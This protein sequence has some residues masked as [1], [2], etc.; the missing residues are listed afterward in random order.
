MVVLSFQHP[1]AYKRRMS[2]W[3]QTPPEVLAA[4]E[5]GWTIL[6]GNQR[7][8]RTLRQSFHAEQR[9][10]GARGWAPP[11][12]YAWETWLG[13]LWRNLVVEGHTSALLLNAHQ[14]HAL[15]REILRAD[16][17]LGASLRPVDSLAE[18]AASGWALLNR[19]GARRDLTRYADTADT[20]AFARWVAEFERRCARGGYLSA[21]RLPEVLAEAF[22]RGDLS[23]GDLSA[24][25]GGGILLVGF[26]RISPDH[27]A[28][29]AAVERAGIPVEE[30]DED[31][32]AGSTQDTTLVAATNEQAE[33]EGCARWLRE[34]LRARP[35]AQAAVIVPELGDLRRRLDR[36]F[37]ELLAPELEDIAAGSGGG[38]YEFSLGVPLA[39]TGLVGTALDLLEWAVKPL[40]VEQVSRLLLSPYLAA[41][42]EYVAR[43]EFDAFALRRETLLV[44]EVS[45]DE[46]LRLASGIR[47]RA[48]LPVLLRYLTAAQRLVER[49]RPAEGQRSHAAWCAV[50]QQFLDTFGWTGGQADDSLEFQIRR[51]WAGVLDELASL[52]FEG[53]TIS[54]TQALDELRRI[55]AGTLFAP[56]SHDAPVQVM[57]P[58]EAA[59]SRFDA[60]WF[61]RAG[62]L[63]WPAGRGAHPLLPQ[64]LQ[65]ERKMPGADPAEESE[66][67]RAIA[68][69]IAASAGTVVF[70]YAQ[71]TSESHQRPSAALAGLALR[72]ATMD[73]LVPAE[74]ARAPVLLERL[75]DEQAIAALPD[76][77]VRGGS[78]IL[79]L[80]AACAFRAFA[81][82]RL[83]SAGLDAPEAGL[84][85]IERG[86]LV[87]AILED[88]WTE[89]E[90]QSALKSLTTAERAEMLARSIGIALDEHVRE[91][92]GWSAAYLEVERERLLTLL[93]RWLEKELERPPFRVLSHEEKVDDFAVGPL[94]VQVRLDRVDVLLRN[95]EAAG[96]I[97]LDYKTGSAA[98][99]DWKGERPDSPQVPLYALVRE[100]GS[101]VG[102]AF[103]TVRPGK[104]MALAGLQAEAGVLGKGKVVLLEEQVEEWRRVL[105]RLAEEFC[106]GVATVAPKQYPTTCRHCEQRLLCRLDPRTLE[107]ESLDDMA[108]PE[109]TDAE[110]ELA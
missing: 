77:V 20:R 75:E 100:P 3:S 49:V 10:A 101:L 82:K 47:N 6:T 76:R 29:L 89:L 79:E 27:K 103:G 67:A 13:T 17:E 86:N 78:K 7:A 80:Q 72:A 69:R 57:G 98:P 54:Y 51:R 8:A 104:G 11:A 15:W 44:P 58:L 63:S 87:H 95:G 5:R 36:A 81:E 91:A 24:E 45:T 107:A 19:F 96:E 1:Q 16:G 62:D 71:E 66:L 73:S 59:G 70:S 102:V 90:T 55:A 4:L 37:R 2:D 32:S 28:L 25:S 14:E 61:L 22:A 34:F 83:S 105:T 23:R 99:A 18:L 106:A 40:A 108:E 38:P 88:V 46:L 56:E 94:R 21:A 109:W 85:A 26:D 92:A 43:A 97:V 35:R 74:T 53:R 84:D 39:S 110:A 30:G 33:L 42:G 60:V 31:Q 65:R 50:F 68:A 93:G 41:G 9:R 48:A 12:V 52:D 64:R